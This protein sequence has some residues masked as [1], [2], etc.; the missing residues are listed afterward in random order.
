MSIGPNMEEEQQITVSRFDRLNHSV[1]KSVDSYFQKPIFYL[2]YI[3]LGGTIISLFFNRSLSREFYLFL[4]ILACLEMKT[5]IKS[6][7]KKGKKNG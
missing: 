7:F 3:S 4:I 5:K 6:I 2:F 1:K